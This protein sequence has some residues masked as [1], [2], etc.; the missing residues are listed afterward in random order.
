M[1]ERVRDV[2]RAAGAA[3]RGERKGL[4][5]AG[6]RELCTLGGLLP[7]S[8]FDYVREAGDP[9]DNGAVA[10]CLG[11]IGDNFP[12]PRL[13]VERAAGEGPPVPVA[14]H[15]LPRLV[16]DPNPYYDGDALLAATAMSYSAF[17]NAYWLKVRDR[18]GRVRE[19]WFLPHE[20]VRPAWPE[21]GSE[22]LSHYV[23]RV[24]GREFSLPRR[25][26]VHFRFGFDP[27]NPR[28]GLSRLWPVLREVVTDNQASTLMAALLRNM[29]IPG[30]LVTP[31][32]ED[33]ELDDGQAETLK[34]L[35]AQ[36]TT[37]ENAGR[38]IVPGVRV[39]VERLGLTPEELVFEKIRQLPEA[40]ICAALRIPAMVVGLSV[41]EHQRT[42]ANLAVARR[43]AYEDCL[44]PM[45]RRF[46]AALNRQ[47]LPELG[48]ASRERVSW[49]YSR[50]AALQ[51]DRTELFQQNTLGVQGGWM[52]RNEARVRVGLPRRP[53]R[54]SPR[55]HRDTEKSRGGTTGGGS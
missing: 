7:G 36:M 49:D 51:D 5:V 20:Q 37:G 14:G 23:Y 34:R 38:A 9:R 30:L 33:A 3:W 10:V 40:R 55:R 8:R 21:D 6:R 29:G 27:R 25:D 52:S 41:G 31:T 47:L 18:A 54:S 46:A 35:V 4:P 2:M 13:M 43:S 53:I 50:V 42:Y 17:G 32:S 39:K 15:A 28:L 44:V 1:L 48:D 45:Q 24:E 11:W 16:E 19:L 12:E 22:F 26:V